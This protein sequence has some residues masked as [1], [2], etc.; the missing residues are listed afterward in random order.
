MHSCY[1][2]NSD[3]ELGSANTTRLLCKHSCDRPVGFDRT[4]IREDVEMKRYLPALLVLLLVGCQQQTEESSATTE[5]VE[6][7]PI[8]VSAVTVKRDLVDIDQ[9]FAG[10]IEPSREVEVQS[11]VTGVLL[12]KHF[13]PGQEVKKGD[14]LYSL[15]PIDYEIELAS[16]NAELIRAKAELTSAE[17]KH[18]RAEK[19]GDAIS[20]QE[21][22]DL[23]ANYQIAQGMHDALAKRVEH[24]ELVLSRSQIKATLDGRIGNSKVEPGDT[25]NAGDILNNIVDDQKVKFIASLNEKLVINAIRE[26]RQGSAEYRVWLKLLNN[27]LYQNEGRLLYVDNEIDPHTGTLKVGFEFDNDDTIFAGQFAKLI[28]RRSAEAIPTP[29]AAVLQD[30]DGSYVYIIEAGIAK[31]RNVVT[32]ATTDSEVM[33]I[34]GISSG[35]QVVIKGHQKIVD[36]VAVETRG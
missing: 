16:L 14:L 36:G 23:Y 13:T 27:E 1:E 10:I 31:R 24:A 20:Q 18:L 32:G 11:R 30:R 28:M 5:A 34:D 35:D 15:D 12:E 19:L 25:I 8:E 3:S 9:E 6:D 4:L 21:R 17:R 22:D 2:W 26:F 29:Q 7:G 33:V